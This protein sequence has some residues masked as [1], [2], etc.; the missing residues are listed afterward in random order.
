MIEKLVQTQFTAPDESEGDATAD[1]TFSEIA[2]SSDNVRAASASADA[3][4]RCL[5]KFLCGSETSII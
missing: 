2:F 1:F 3:L 5:A 4:Q